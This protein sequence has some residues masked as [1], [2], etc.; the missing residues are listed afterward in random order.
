VVDGLFARVHIF[1]DAEAG[2]AR[3]RQYLTR[4]ERPAVLL[5]LGDDE[6]RQE[7]RRLRGL[8][9]AM[10]VLLLRDGPSDVAGGGAVIPRPPGHR[11]ASGRDLEAEG[12]ALCEAL[13]PW[14]TRADGATPRPEAVPKRYPD[15]L[16]RLAAASRQLRERVSRGD[17]MSVVLGFAAE[18]FPRV[19]IFMVR[20]GQAV[21]LV[22]RG[23][24]AAGGPDAGALRQLQLPVDEPACFRAVLE[25]R[26]PQRG[27]PE[28]PGDLRLV[29]SL[30]Q[31]IPAE[32]YVAPI[33][34]GGRVA[35]LLYADALPAQR[36]VG[37]AR[38]VEIVVHEAGLALD[39][40]LLR[41][42]LAERE[43]RKGVDPKRG[44]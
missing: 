28:G 41:H 14:A 17:V 5:G 18:T 24:P 7:V 34:S 13:A 27:R 8:C 16:E 9:A 6:V 23:L 35:A 40:A 32:V 33:E 12:R 30:G 37:D 15:P 4:G 19:A 10:P 22:G 25:T 21:G 36:S 29:R 38:A 2:A 26:S 39:H 43:G 11:L 31:A 20:K 3:V 1:Q 42:A 44:G